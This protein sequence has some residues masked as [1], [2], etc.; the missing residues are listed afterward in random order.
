VPPDDADEALFD[1]LYTPSAPLSSI[2]H[3]DDYGRQ[4][5]L[6]AAGIDAPSALE[7]LV[8]AD[9]RLHS[10]VVKIVAFGDERSSRLSGHTLIMPHEALA[11]GAKGARALAAD[12]I[13]SA[14]AQV[15]VRFVGPTGSQT[16]LEQSALKVDDLRLRGH[17]LYNY[18]LMRSVLR[19]LGDAP[20]PIGEI[21]RWI[22]ESGGVLKTARHLD[23]NIDKAA[24][25]D[26]GSNVRAGASKEARAAA[27]ADDGAARRKE[28]P[29][30]F[31]ESVG[32]MKVPEQEMG[33]VINSIA[34]AFDNEA[35]EAD[36]TSQPPA[37]PQPSAKDIAMRRAD[38]PCDDY[39]GVS[40]SLYAAF[41]SLLILGRGLAR[42]Q[43]LPGQK[44][45]HMMTYYDNR[46]ADCLPLLFTLA[47]MKL[48]HAV[49]RAVGAKVI[50]S[51]PAFREF[52]RTVNDPSFPALLKEA[53]ADPDGPAAKRVLQHV[54]RFINLSGRAVP[55]GTR[56]RAAE[57]TKLLAEQRWDGA[58]STFFNLA[59]DDVHDIF[60]IR[61][62]YPFK[63][64]GE[65][66]AVSTDGFLTA[67]RR[68]QDANDT[69]VQD[70]AAAVDRDAADLGPVA[71]EMDEAALQMRA[72]RHPV[73]CTLSFEHTVK[74]VLT[75]LIR[76]DVLREKK[77]GRE[78]TEG[79]PRRFDE[80]RFCEGKQQARF[81][82]HTLPD[83][84]WRY[85][86]SHFGRRA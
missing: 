13:A 72:A 16:H 80:L 22:D 60:A 68:Q 62:S 4:L 51:A 30:P 7:Q 15:H 17:V 61:Y 64:R 59:P 48:R 73:A 57:I 31:L 24:A 33:A 39:T 29:P 79:R 67:M 55:W 66:P 45:R 63:G 74:N 32:V 8:L 5:H 58:S 76:V 21:L 53:Q 40:T 9:A 78:P 46:M 43:A 2:A 69:R 37:P 14:L 26:D 34:D 23:E 12:K 56:E 1:D 71:F 77:R 38:D 65:F 49:N 11:G 28:T 86:R 42:D 44:Y 82:A 20:P 83:Q 85:S 27:A 25:P 35:D 6:A 54:L 3:G 19:A 70:D 50:S 10:I 36:G 84:G 47:N 52:T 81:I 18:S 41:W 75:N